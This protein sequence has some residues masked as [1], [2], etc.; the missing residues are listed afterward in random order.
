MA[1]T[2]LETQILEEVREDLTTAENWDGTLDLREAIADGI[3]EAS[4]FGKYFV[5]KTLISLIADVA[6]YSVSL[7]G[8]YPLSIIGARLL[9]QDRELEATTLTGLSNNSD[10]WLIS[11]GAPYK[12][13][14]LSNDTLIVWPCYDS[15][16]G[17]IELD[18]ICTPEHYSDDKDWV[19]IGEELEQALVSYGKYSLL[20]QTG[21]QEEVA[22]KEYE[23]YLRLIKATHRLSHHRRAVNRYR[24]LERG[25]ERA[26]I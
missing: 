14:P 23:N 17:V 21:G 18:V 22:L 11:R 9:E 2:D 20:M 4:M 16:G 25:E 10:N 13:V 24:F 6:F 8:H 3:D 15:D 19:S 26:R 7:E 5:E 1:L 12:Y